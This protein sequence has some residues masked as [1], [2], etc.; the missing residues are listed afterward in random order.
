MAKHEVDVWIRNATSA[1]PPDNPSG[2]GGPGSA[3]STQSRGVTVEEISDDDGTHR[4]QFPRRTADTAGLPAEMCKSLPFPMPKEQSLIEENLPD[5]TSPSV[6]LQRRCLLCFSGCKPNL[7]ACVLSIINTFN[8]LTNVS[9][10][11]DVIVCI[12]A[13]FSQRRRHSRYL[14]PEDPHPDTH[15]LPAQE[16]EAMKRTVNQ[17]RPSEIRAHSKPRKGLPD[18]VL[19]DCEKMFILIKALFQHLPGDWTVSLLYDVA[20]QLERSM[21]KVRS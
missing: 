16:V 2:A 4:R 1:T 18:E 13:N 5:T 6:Y 19:N 15:F 12:D 3:T 21:R 10:S 11:G 8:I 7:Q 17:V 9:D 14:D 20:C